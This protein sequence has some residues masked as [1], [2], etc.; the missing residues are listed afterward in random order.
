MAELRLQTNNRRR[1][2]QNPN[3][4]IACTYNAVKTHEF[5]SKSAV[6]KIFA[7]TP[8]LDFTLTEYT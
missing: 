6:R 7:I 1:Q 3:A 4:I 5:K 2:N 8:K